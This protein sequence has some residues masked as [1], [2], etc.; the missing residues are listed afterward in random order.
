MRIVL[1]IAIVLLTLRPSVAQD[2]PVA[3]TTTTEASIPDSLRANDLN[4]QSSELRKQ[5]KYEEAVSI[6]KE[7]ME[8]AEQ[9]GQPDQIA[10]AYINIGNVLMTQG[11]EGEVINN[12]RVEKPIILHSKDDFQ[13]ARYYTLLG[14]CY[15]DTRQYEL[16][17]KN[18]RNAIHYF[19]L[20]DNGAGGVAACYSNLGN[21]FAYQGNN[22]EALQHFLKA[23]KINEDQKNFDGMAGDYTRIGIHHAKTNNLKEAIRSF[24]RALEMAQEH[25]LSGQLPGIY[26]N[27]ANALKSDG[28]LKAAETDLR[29]SIK[30]SKD[31]GRQTTLARSNLG[32]AACLVDQKR[33]SEVPPYLDE[34]IELSK[35]SNNKD[36]LMYGYLTMARLDSAVGNYPKAFED[37]K[38]FLVYKDSLD[39]EIHS[40]ETTQ[41]RTLYETERKDK[42]IV[43]L[44]KDREIQTKELSRQKL[45]R[46]GFVGGFAVIL[47]FSIAI[48]FQSK[49][50]A[51]EKKRSEDL[52]LNILPAEVA[53][54]LKAKGAADTRLFDLV[55]VLFTDFK[56]FTAL[57]E[58]L[59]PQELVAEINLCFSAFDRIMEKYGVE[60]IKTIGD[61]YMAAGGLPVPNETH[62]HN[63]V[64]AALDIQEF[65]EQRMK[66]R[67]SDAMPFF[68]IRIGVHTGPVVA[69]IVGIKKFQYDIWGDTV[70]TAARLESSGTE[71]KVNVSSSTYDLVKKHFVCTPRGKIAAKGKGELEMYYVER[72]EVEV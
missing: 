69:G 4:I 52:L 49:R 23:S 45:I 17:I 24:T 30:I 13:I 39:K 44:E 53:E 70:N 26:H 11:R 31:M 57:S 47:L 6:A 54:E 36:L 59:T 19:E 34:G 25:N 37:Y 71:G 5:G 16:A 18:F 9:L 7:A 65:M 1:V 29:M 35:L 15:S 58:Q 2:K 14:M 50:I 8:L 12:I 41:M 46:N 20:T 60:K 56:G 48:A 32:L 43:S 40:K 61:A 42:E 27:R 28:Q 33:L 67:K 68:E 62:A 63:V 10:S 64:S 51:K 72:K 66:E 55:T 3:K 22:E 38:L 21:L